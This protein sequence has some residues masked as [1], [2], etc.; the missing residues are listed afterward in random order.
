MKSLMTIFLQFVRDRPTRPNILA[1]FR[2]LAFVALVIVI[3]SILF[4]Y[5][6]EYEGRSYSWI[7]GFYWTLTV[8]STLGFGDITF[9]S[10]LGRLFSALVLLSGV[11]FLLIL[12]PFTFIEFFYAPWM[13]A[14]EAA[15]APR[16][17]PEK[18]S[19]HAVLTRFDPVTVALI[20]KLTQYQYSYV[21]LIADL[22]EALRLHDMGYR[23]MLGDLDDPETYWRARVN[24]ALFV[25]ATGSDQAN[26]NVAFTVREI[27]ESVPVIAVA[28][29][30]ASV[31]ILELAGCSHVLEL[32]E[33]MGQALA[34]QVVDD[35]T[36]AHVIGQF[37]DLLIAE[38]A[39]R[40][41]SLV[42]KTLQESDLRVRTGINVLGVWERGTFQSTLG[43]TRITPNTTLILAG[44]E[45]DLN[46]YNERFCRGETSSAMVVIIGGGRVGRATG[47]AL[48]AKGLNYRI[49]EKNPERI[50]PANAEQY[51]LGDAA[52]LEVLENAGIRQAAAVIV[53]T[54]DDDMNVYLTIYC[55]RLR[56]DAQILSRA[57]LDR[58]VVTLHRA[59]ADF[60]MSYASTGANAIMNLI[61]RDNIL[62]VAE[63]LDIFEVQIPPSLAGRTVAESDIRSKTGCTV[64]AIQR[65]QKPQLL[66]DPHEPLPSTCR[67][68]L[69][70]TPEAEENFLKLYKR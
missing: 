62:M 17:L 57:V 7:T 35:A 49:V 50:L 1:L 27:S 53:T 13:R 61:G 6:M 45:A 43:D 18:T 2:F 55:R 65:D 29:T 19:R 46:R 15:R 66:L 5:L 11:I 10:D 41:T 63:G 24:Q 47:R 21:V 52:E 51:V 48:A 54:H 39:A 69:I 12:L 30:H 28:N 31:D 14:Q 40:G 36:R 26:T 25:A 33:I 64:V 23:V 32:G 16:E 42:G 60:V 9:Q 67:L 68:I 34:R 22:T 3:Y 8:M 58:N 4:H 20:D 37:D 44:T 59:G 56:P 38:A 70:G